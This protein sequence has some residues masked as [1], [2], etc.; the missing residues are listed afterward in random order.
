M[1]SVATK[2]QTTCELLRHALGWRPATEM[3][4]FHAAYR[5]L[6]LLRFLLALA[7][8]YLHPD[9]YFQ[10]FEPAASLALSVHAEPPAWEW[11]PATASSRPIRSWLVPVLSCALPM[12]LMAALARVFGPDLPSID[13][14]LLLWATRLWMCTLSLLQDACLVGVCRAN[15]WPVRPA[16]LTFASCWPT[17]VLSSR[18]FS[19]TLE[20]LALALALLVATRAPPDARPDRDTLLGALLAAGCMCRF[21]FVLFWLPLLGLPLPGSALATTGTAAAARAAAVRVPR[22][23]QGALPTAAALLLLDCWL[24]GGECRGAPWRCIAPLNALLYNID[25]T[26]LQRHGLHP[27]ASHLL[28]HLPLLL[29]PAA[30]FPAAEAMARAA[31]LVAPRGGG[32]GPASLATAVGTMAARRGAVLR[33]L[34]LLPL[35]AL[36]C[37]P[38]QEARFLLPLLLPAAALYGAPLGR[39]RALVALHLAFHLAA[40][41][42]FG[43]VHQAGLARLLPHVGRMPAARTTFFAYTYMPPG[44]LL[45]RQDGAPHRIV[46]LSEAPLAQLAAALAA[47][48]RASDAPPQLALP[49]AL[50]PALEAELARLGRCG[51]WRAAL[52]WRRRRRLQLV[53]LRSFWPH[54][55]AE[56]LG[57]LLRMDEG[58]AHVA[59]ALTLDLLEL[60]CAAG[61]PN[62]V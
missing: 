15:V 53:R 13:G 46:D 44:A 62:T 34:L 42:F 38:H 35:A 11:A 45:G 14:A 61:V 17:L 47:S 32:G 60:R 28:L 40:A 48:W 37:A 4:R 26:N 59:T 30:L 50:R 27:R 51:G 8:G 19:N 2:P 22:L 7:P 6:L 5:T 33:G 24:H 10:S 18:P 1:D 57:E 31:R 55:S 41:A 39:R 25:P 52:P 23:L 56:L 21:T 12:R 54:F 20:S 49:A 9:E 29:G 58:R 43:G 16:L 36:S 3:D